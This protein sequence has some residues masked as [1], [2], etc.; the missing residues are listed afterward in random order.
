MAK[1]ELIFAFFGKVKLCLCL[2]KSRV[3]KTYPSLS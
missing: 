1:F 2:T 3:M